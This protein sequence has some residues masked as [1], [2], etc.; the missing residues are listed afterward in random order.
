MGLVSYY[1]NSVFNA[2]LSQRLAD[3]L[4]WVGGAFICSNILAFVGF[5]RMRLLRSP[6]FLVLVGW[7]FVLCLSFILND[8]F[9]I[10]RSAGYS[11]PY[12]V[13]GLVLLGVSGGARSKLVSSVLKVPLILVLTFNLFTI[14]RTGQ[15]VVAHSLT[16]D[17]IIRRISPKDLEW[18][19]LKASLS[20]SDSTPVLISGFR[21]TVEPHW[22]ISQIEPIPN[23][24]GESISTFWHIFSSLNPLHGNLTSHWSD[25]ELRRMLVMP[26]WP[27][28]NAKYLAESKQAIVPVGLPFPVEWEQWR[29]IIVTKRIH[30]ENICDV[31]FRSE[32][33]L[34]LDPGAVGS[35][36]KDEDGLY[37][38]LLNKSRVI[39]DAKKNNC[40]E[41]QA[42]FDG[43]KGS[44]RFTSPHSDSLGEVRMTGKKTQI[45]APVNY[46]DSLNLFIVKQGEAKKLRSLNVVAR[47]CR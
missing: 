15:Y 43:T 44:V 34:T 3:H 33:S 25:E 45:V 23:F 16:T 17:K 13:I 39:F 47:D 22:I 18:R 11:V 10:A 31:V 9:R 40:F 38:L 7:F 29:D 42:I 41:L 30:F 21:S 28:L 4:P 26:D 2:H 35:L 24:L 6:V 32:K 20:P 46:E 37:R 36:E 5:Q 27:V 8:P 12:V 19:E 1:D 14:W